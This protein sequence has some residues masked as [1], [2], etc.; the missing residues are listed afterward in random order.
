MAIYSF[1]A[2]GLSPS[3]GSSAVKTAA[4]N[5]AL[6]IRRERTGELADYRRRERVAACGIVAPPDAPAWA[7]DRSR[8]WNEA[9]A[10]WGGGTE[11]VARLYKAALPRELSPDERTALVERFCRALSDG[12]RRAVDWAIHVDP[13]GVNPHVHILASALPIG[14]G[15]F[16]RPAA[17]KSTKVYLCRD[18]GG[19]DVMVAAADWKAAK[20]RGIEKVYN[21]RDGTRR[22]M[23]QA[24]AEG[25]TR[26]DRRSKT[27]VA[28]TR[29][30]SGARAFDAERAAL[31]DLR[32]SWADAVN[33]ALDGHR[34]A[35]GEA[36][37]HVDHRSNA[38]RGLDALPTVHEG[39]RVTE[40]ERRAERAAAEAGRPYEPVT[41]VRRR[42]VEIRSLNA[43]IAEAWRDLVSAVRGRDARAAAAA[44]RFGRAAIAGAIGG[45]IRSASD[46]IA[47][48]RAAEER[49]RRREVRREVRAEWKR[50]LPGVER[51]MRER[52]GGPVDREIIALDAEARLYEEFGRRGVAKGSE[53]AK[54][55]GIR[56]RIAELE[57]RSESAA[58]ARRMI[59]GNMRAAVRAA[60]MAGGAGRIGGDAP[61]QPQR[62]QREE[63]P[64]RGRAEDRGDRGSD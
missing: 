21:F 18:A 36:V 22:T 62:Q 49:A 23:S 27:P 17:P 24:K 29:T 61:Q 12:G 45:A 57:P 19:A 2:R 4:Y 63:M 6:P 5:S 60:K 15:G 52:A 11:L 64:Q 10:A 8:L 43:A 37:A 14:P 3:S 41:D 47:E 9:E 40:M 53:A 31:V 25:L 38:E 54:A 59:A 42:N 20:A 35:T 28:V 30:A 55:A 32:R 46:R 48:R 39:P 13:D 26:D 7:S 56:A 44:V 33:A 16:E 34:D 51:A 50:G 58:E 1:N